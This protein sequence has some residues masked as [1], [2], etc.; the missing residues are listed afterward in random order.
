M[1]DSYMDERERSIYEAGE[2]LLAE[3]LRQNI[4]A[5]DAAFQR[6]PEEYYAAFFKVIQDLLERVSEVQKQGNK[7]ALQYICISYLQSSLY[8]GH[9]QLRFDAYD[10][11]QF[12][13]VT[14]TYAYWSPDFIFQYIAEDIAHFRRHVSKHIIR[15][16]EH[17]IMHF[18]AR[19]SLHYYQI[20]RQFIAS[21]IESIISQIIPDAEALTVTFGGYMDQTEVLFEAEKTQ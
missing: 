2:A 8:T 7:G 10:D 19:Y 1:G 5:I 9:Y 20:V 11:R 21:L 13:D 6:A 4:R 18:A 3:R 12:G 15:I 16:Q 14:D 17:E